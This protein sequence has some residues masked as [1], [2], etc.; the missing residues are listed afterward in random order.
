MLRLDIENNHPARPR[1]IAGPV[2]MRDDD[3]VILGHA[4]GGDERAAIPRRFQLRILCS[5]LLLG[6][7]R[8]VVIGHFL[9]GIE[10][11]NIPDIEIH[12]LRLD[13]IRDALQLLLIL[14]IDM[15]PEHL[16]SGS[17][18]EFPILPRLVHVE[19]FDGFKRILDLRRQEITM[20]IADVGRRALEMNVRPAS[21][22]KSISLLQSSIRGI[23]SKRTDGKNH[24]QSSQ[25]C[26][27]HNIFQREPLISNLNPQ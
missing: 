23:S 21:L 26:K 13:S 7:P 9:E 1:Q 10:R 15:R 24:Y 27:P 25:T 11:D 19:Q 16:T 6:Q 8:Q 17:P 4:S 20:L 5:F 12:A 2:V 14:A 3:L 18:E 22:L